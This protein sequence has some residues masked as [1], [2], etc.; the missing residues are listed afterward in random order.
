MSTISDCN[1]DVQ[2]DV[3]KKFAKDWE[4]MRKSINS[5]D[6]I[7]RIIENNR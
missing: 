2:I 6:K 1:C 3:F 7:S 4:D 5:I